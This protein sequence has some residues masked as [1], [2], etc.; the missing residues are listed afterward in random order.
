MRNSPDPIL[1]LALVFAIGA[2]ATQ[3]VM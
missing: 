1:L 3:F 2:V